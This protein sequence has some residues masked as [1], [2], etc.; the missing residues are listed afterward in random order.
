MGLWTEIVDG[1]AIGPTGYVPIRDRTAVV[2]VLWDD[3]RGVQITL[4]LPDI[5]M[6][7]DEVREFRVVIDQ[8]MATPAPVH[9][10]AA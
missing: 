9:R 3:E 2:Q 8:L 7:L 6:T 10:L 1:T 5:C 4:D